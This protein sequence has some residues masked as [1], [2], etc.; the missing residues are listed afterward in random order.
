MGVRINTNVDA[1]TAM[2]NLGTTDAKFRQSVERLSS[3]MR[4]NRAADDAAGLSIS[5]TLRAQVRGTAQAS[6]NAQDAISMIQTAE[7]AL[8]EI[9]AMLQRM[10]ELAVQ[11]A[12]DTLTDT[13]RVAVQAEIDQLILEGDAT[14]ARTTFNTKP[15]LDGVET[16]IFQVGPNEADEFD[17]SDSFDDVTAATLGVD[18]L[19]VSTQTAANNAITTMD[20]GI[21]T[22]SATRG[23]LG[24]AQNRL[25]HAVA[26]L[27]V[28]NENMAAAESRIRDADIAMES[29][30]FNQALILRQAGTMVLAQANSAPNSVLALLQG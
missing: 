29:V 30:K 17:A 11:A 27:D 19:D 2:R 8:N 21:A 18:P 5:E 10:R 15:L 1:I 25:Q 23:E 6:R 13:D 9:H 3:G 14:V 7:G 26:N 16:F 28:A 22:L 20:T 4:V 12:N 24:A